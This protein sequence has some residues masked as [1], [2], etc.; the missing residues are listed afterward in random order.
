MVRRAVNVLPVNFGESPTKELKDAGVY[1]AVMAERKRDEMHLHLQSLMDDK[2]IMWTHDTWNKVR[3]TIPHI[4][5]EMKHNGKIKVVP[6][7]AIK[8]VIGRSP[9]ELDAV[10]LMIQAVVTDGINYKEHIV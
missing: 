3:D 1:A 8:A 9:D 2:A 6:K 4:K 5:M 7:Q 10:L